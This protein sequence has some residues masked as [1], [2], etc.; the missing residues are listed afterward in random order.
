MVAKSLIKL[1]DEA[2]IPAIA[3][4]VGKL[5][6][7]LITTYFF[8]LPFAI[9]SR[10]LFGILPSI[11]FTN[12]SDYVLA[13]NYSNLAMF[14][15]AALGTILVLVRAHFFHESHVHPNLHAKL[16]SLN[17]ESLIAPTYH[18]YHQAAIWLIFLWLSVGFLIIS[19]IIQATYPYV[20]IVAFIIAAN[21]SWIFAIDVEKEIEIARGNI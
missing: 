3:L 18:L 10:E 4:I 16:M 15:I 14:S 19:T 6:G 13:E 12:L 20:A 8:Q 17:L 1:I 21:F 5:L 11:H 9:K 2:I 7:L